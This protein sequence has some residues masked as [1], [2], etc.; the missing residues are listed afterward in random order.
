M[1]NLALA[2]RL[3]RR[4]LRGG[5][6]GFR[7]AL[8]ALAVGVASIA[9]VGALDRAIEDAMTGQ[10]RTL[11]GGDASV[12]TTM[13]AP[14]ADALAFLAASGRV[15]AA[16]ELY[17]MAAGPDGRAVLAA[18]KAVDDAY[19]LLGQVALDPPMA[20]ADALAV[21]DAM[22]GAV[23]HPAL[24]AAL[25]VRPGD[26]ITLGKATFAVRALLAAEPDRAASPFLLGERLMLSETGL[27]AA[28]LVQPGSLVRHAWR[29]LLP[30]GADARA[31]ASEAMARFPDAGWR[32]VQPDEANTQLSRVLTRIAT[33]LTLVG[34]G[35]LVVGGIGVAGAAQT[36][37]EGKTE[38]I[39]ILKALGASGGLVLAVY[40]AEILALTALGVVA[41]AAAGALVP[42]I[43]AWLA[44]AALPVAVGWAPRPGPLALAALFG[45]LVALVF[46]LWPLG[47]AREVP[48]AALFREVAAK[49]NGRPRAVLVGAIVALGAL[50]VAVA[51]TASGNAEL[52]LWFCAATL[53]ALVGLR[54][55]AFAIAR[56]ARGV[57]HRRHPVVR[58]ALAGLS[59]PGAAT[60]PVV[61][62][63]GTGLALLAAVTQLE[64]NLRREIVQVLPAEAPSFF[65]LDIQPVQREPFRVLV[66]AVPGGELIGSVPALRGRIVAID[67]VPVEKAAIDPQ[68]RWAIEN[69]R[70]VTFAATPPEGSD[71]V[72]GA[73]WPADYQGPPLVSLDARIAEGFGIAVGDRITVSVLGRAIE[74][75]VANLRRIAWETLAINFTL[76]FDPAALAAAPYTMIATVRVPPAEEAGLRTAVVRALPNVSA[77]GVSEVLAKVAG[78]VD[79]AGAALAGAAAVAIAAGILVLGQAVAADQ[80]RRTYD[81]V[82]LKILGAT[83]AQVAAAFALE[84]IALGLAT[85]AI[86]A[87]IGAL[88]AWVVMTDLLEGTFVLLPGE[89]ALTIAIGIAAP[90][91]LGGL[92]T[93]RAL[94]AKAAPTLRAA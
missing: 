47:R 86:G 83:R 6:R 2:L 75:E 74:A 92:G 79:Q 87:A 88:G 68:A 78:I 48:A 64:G 12:Q 15:S 93:W 4:D 28:G 50:L 38:T 23:P 32:I 82:I 52:A 91:L 80:R 34:L 31:W 85:G 3:A 63:L 7:A 5:A 69:D 94:G 76:V 14:P 35:A 57:A 73:W 39:A 40:L 45:F 84:H 65:F 33:Y 61:M 44:P 46:A 54:A 89:L 77:V 66:D 10:A 59:R 20:L 17:G 9:G 67:G 27:A 26:T 24:A 55:L 49:A 22:A 62:A 53:A 25:G 1:T 90:L 43:V 21:K 72:A 41:G 56:A 16:T 58:L 18:V 71:V 70:G 30:A 29:I 42:G 60:A 37:L 8:V 81:A 11:L 51:A 36:Y 19:P 13:A